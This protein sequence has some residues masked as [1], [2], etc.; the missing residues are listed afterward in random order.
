MRRT[1]SMAAVLMALAA[2]AGC[3]SDRSTGPTADIAGT[4]QMTT[5]NGAALPYTIAAG[6]LSL[7]VT[8][9]VLVLN[10]D[11][12]YVDSTTFAIPNGA[13]TQTSISMERGTFRYG[14]DGSISFANATS[15]GS[16]YSGRIAGTTL[17][18]SVHGTTPV[19]E[20]Q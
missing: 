4:Y 8:R 6:S 15:G 3:R 16:S 2:I 10:A 5:M 20:R 14:S 7:Q 19:Y 13:R 18:E 12:S 1:A 11:G 9:D 17:T